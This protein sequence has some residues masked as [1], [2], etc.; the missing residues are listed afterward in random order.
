MFGIA[1]SWKIIAGMGLAI[2]ILCGAVWGVWQAKKAAETE[3][4]RVEGELAQ[5]IEVN[6]A[7]ALEAERARRQEEADRRTT[8]QELDAT[9]QRS[10]TITVLKKEQRNAPDANDAAGPYFDDFADRLR[11]SRGTGP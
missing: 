2:L 9:A 3:L 7:N 4:E 1:A 11:Q 8:A 6:K 5:A 10:N